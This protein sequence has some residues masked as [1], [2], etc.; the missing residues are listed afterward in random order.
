MTPILYILA[1]GVLMRG[2]FDYRTINP[3][4][5]YAGLYLVV[6]NN[7]FAFVRLFKLKRKNSLLRISIVSNFLIG[8]YLLIGGPVM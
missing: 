7:I 8:L 2:H 6:L 3:F 5:T 4:V 1:Y